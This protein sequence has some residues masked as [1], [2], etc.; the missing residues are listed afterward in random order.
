MY[1]PECLGDKD[2]EITFLANMPVDKPVLFG[3]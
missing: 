3:I 1:L 2:Y